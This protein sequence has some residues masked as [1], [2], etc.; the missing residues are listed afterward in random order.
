MD[1]QRHWFTLLLKNPVADSY[2]ELATAWLANLL[3][4]RPQ[5][6]YNCP[7]SVWYVDTDSGAL[8]A[9]ELVTW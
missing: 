8:T 3:G 7:V 1:S 4:C 6:S 5:E 9:D 2:L